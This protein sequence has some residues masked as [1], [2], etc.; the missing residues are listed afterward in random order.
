P[1]A[2]ETFTS[3]T[4]ADLDEDGRDDL[5]AAVSMGSGGGGGPGAIQMRMLRLDTDGINDTINISSIAAPTNLSQRI[6][7]I[8][9]GRP[10][11][12]RW[13]ALSTD[14]KEVTVFEGT[15]IRQ[16]VPFSPMT[17]RGIR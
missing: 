15:S 12:G 14:G 9:P 2:G 16:T 8:W 11:R 3:I 6:T 17:V 1:N 7:T 13:A 4:A 5:V 10:N